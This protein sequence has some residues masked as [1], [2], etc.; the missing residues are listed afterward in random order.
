MRKSAMPNSTNGRPCVFD[1]CP[2][3]ARSDSA[4]LCN[5]HYEQKRN[6]RLLTPLVQW[7]KTTTPDGLCSFNGCDRPVYG[8]NLC[9]THYQQLRDGRPIA[10]I[11][12]PT[13]VCGRDGCERPH[14]SKGL[15]PHHYRTAGTWLT[16]GE[17]TR[18]PGPAYDAVHRQINRGRGSAADYVCVCGE[19]AVAWA[20]DNDSPNV[21]VD[22]GNGL[23][24]SLYPA[25]YS[26]MCKAC[27]EEMDRTWRKG[28]K[29]AG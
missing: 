20:L 13:L 9:N 8:N 12:T 18:V 16:G 15:C 21:I 23:R 29:A 7:G 1:G 4:D 25:D 24:F 3:S 11:F 6:G 14:H 17:P 22:G 28:H 5:G 19:A 10:P 2:R 26:P 27:H